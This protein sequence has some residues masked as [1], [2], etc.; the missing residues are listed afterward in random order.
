M[1]SQADF[2]R[3]KAF[4]EAHARDL[5]QQLFAFIFENG[6][7]QTVLDALAAFQNP[8]GGFGYGLEPD[9]R[10]SVS[11]PIATTIAFHYLNAIGATAKDDMIKQAIAY[12]VDAYVQRD[13]PM[14]SGW[15]LKLPAFDDAPHAIWWSYD[16]DDEW[17]N[18]DAEIVAYL[19][20]FH[21]LVPVD[22]LDEVNAIAKHQAVQIGADIEM[23]NFNCFYRLLPYMPALEPTVLEWA[24]QLIV[25]DPNEWHGYVLT[26]LAVF[27]GPSAPFAAHFETA[28]QA[29]L[30][31]QLAQQ[32]ADG[33]WYPTWAWPD[34]PDVWVKVRLEIAGMVTVNTLRVFQNYS[35]IEGLD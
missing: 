26:P 12:L 10:A 7:P 21:S 35:Y 27:N 18:P 34:Y 30:A 32:Q 20:Q 33:G 11:S 1:L 17:G 3:A 25:T 4:I 14:Q 28:I 9:V 19:N 5:D 16:D 13:D 23:H 8:D 6:S 31:F 15:P 2:Q 29:N 22:F 24:R